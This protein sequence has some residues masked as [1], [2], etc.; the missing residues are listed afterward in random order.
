MAGSSSNQTGLDREH[1]LYIPLFSRIGI[2]F[3]LSSL[4]LAFWFLLSHSA[5]DCNFAYLAW[6]VNN[7]IASSSAVCALYQRVFYDIQQRGV[8][9]P[10]FSRYQIPLPHSSFVRAHIRISLWRAPQSA[11]NVIEFLC[12]HNSLLTSRFHDVSYLLR[13][14]QMYTPVKWTVQ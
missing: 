5:Y 11:Q 6:H 10:R 9:Q 13:A 7:W 2:P 14:P 3:K 4:S 8:S 12:F 1:G